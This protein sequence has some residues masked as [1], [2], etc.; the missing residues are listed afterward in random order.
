MIE[1]RSVVNYIQSRNK[2]YN[3][4]EEERCLQLI[5][6]S[7]D[8]FGANL[9]S[10]L[11]SGGSLVLLN[12]EKRKS[13]HLIPDII[14]RHKVTQM[15]LVPSMYKMI[16]ENATVED[17]ESVKKVILAA[18]KA[19]AQ[20]L[21]ESKRLNKDI[22]LINEYGPT[23]NTIGTTYHI[24]MRSEE[25]ANIGRPFANIKIY[26]LDQHQKLVPTGVPGEIYIGGDG[27]ARGYYNA[28]ELTAEKF[29]VLEDF[30][31]RL[32]RTGDLASW[33]ENGELLYRGRID[34]QIK[35]R[36]Y[37]VELGEIESCIQTYKD[38]QDTIVSAY[39]DKEGQTYLCAYYTAK[40]TIEI[41]EIK[42][43]LANTLPD[44]MVP[45]CF[46]QLEAFPKLPN[47]KVDKKALPLPKMNHY[48]HSEYEAPSDEIEE[49]L[50]TIWQELLEAQKISVL[51]SFFNLGGQS[52]KATVLISKIYKVFG[53]EIPLKEI[54]KHTTVKAQAQYIRASY[55]TE[56]A[57]IVKVKQQPYYPLSSTQKRLYV[58]HQLANE[59]TLYNTPVMLEI[60]GQMDAQKIEDIFNKLIQRHEIFRTQFIRI[61]DEIVQE[62]LK[63]V[64]FKVEKI[65]F[66]ERIEES[67]DQFVRPFILDKAP[68][69]RVGLVT[70]NEMHHMLLIDMHHII[71]DGVSGQ[72]L[73]KEFL[74]LY[75][76]NALNP[77]EVQ[78]KDY[79][80][81]QN[82]LMQSE[83]FKEEENYWLEV[84]K[85]ELPVLNLQTD[86]ARPQIQSFEGNSIEFKLSPELT[87]S[88]KALARDTECTLYMLLLAAYNV[89]LYKYTNQEDFIIGTPI[90]GRT[91]VDSQEMLGVFVN[92][93]AMRFYP[94]G[95]KS[96]KTFLEEVK[97]M[98]LEAYA[99]QDYQLEDLIDKLQVQRDL[100]RN[101]LFDT[102]F[103]VQNI[104]A[105]NQFIVENQEFNIVDMLATT[106]KFDLNLTV[107]E[108]ETLVVT[109]EYCTK[110]FKKESIK[111]LYRH[112][113]NILNSIVIDKEVSLDNITMLST[114]EENQI[115]YE[116]NDTKTSY[117]S[118]KGLI[119][120]FEEQVLRTPQSIALVYNNE[121]LTYET[122]AQKVDQLA[123][124]LSQYDIQKDELIGLMVPRSIEMIIGMLAILKVGGAYLPIDY[125]YPAERINYMLKDS[126]ARI[127]LSNDAL[128]SDIQFEGITLPL[129]LEKIQEMPQSLRTNLSV[130][131]GNDLA[132]IMYT[133]GSTGKPKGVMV[134]QKNVMR[135]VKNTNY[136]KF[137]PGSSIL[138]TGAI[139]FDASTFEVWGALLNGLTLYLV[140]EAVLLNAKRLEQAIRMYKINILWLTSPLFN[141]LVQQ[142]AR[143]FETL[144]YLLVGGDVLSYKHIS[145]VREACPGVQIINGYGPTENTTFSTCYPINHLDAQSIPIGKPISNSMAYVVNHLGALQAIGIPGELWVGGDGVARGYLNQADLTK[146]KFVENPFGLGKLYKTGDLVKWDT[147]GNLIFL[148]RID[149]QVK[150]RGFRIEIGEIERALLAIAYIQEAVIKVIGNSSSEKYLCAYIVSNE[151]IDI[152]KL[153]TCLLEK[154]PEYMLPTQY[155][156]L[157]ALPLNQNGKVDQSL[158]P[159][160]SDEVVIQKNH[161]SPSNEIEEKLV[162]I[163]QEL[164]GI[165]P[166]GVE[167]NFFELGGHSLKATTLMAQVQRAFNVEI[168]LQQIFKTPTIRQLAKVIAVSY[169][170]G[171]TPIEAAE[172]QEYYP[173]SSAQKRMYILRS[174]EDE[175][176][177]NYNIPGILL[178]EGNL[179]V[180]RVEEIF[181]ELVNR[182]EILRTSFEVIDGQVYQ[183]VNESVTVKVEY[184][185]ANDLS[186]EEVVKSSIYPF[187]LE[188][189][190]L[191]RVKLIKLDVQKHLLVYD[192]HHIISD[193]VSLGIIA[194]EF[195]KLYNNETLETIKLHYKDYAVWQNKMINSEMMKEQETYWLN[196]FAGELP[197]L[198]LKTDYNRPSIQSTEGKTFRVEVDE[199][200]TIKLKQLAQETGATLYMLLLAAYNVLIYK[201]TG[202]E[203]IIIG[204]P[205]AGRSQADLEQM[206]GMFVNTLAMRSFP[207]G[208][209]TFIE[210]LME[211]KENALM[212]YAHQ[213]Y[214][215][216]ELIDKLNLKR[217]MSRNPLF[218]CMFSLQNM[219]EDIPSQMGDVAITPISF[220]LN[221]AKFDLSIDANEIGTKI[222]F[223]FQYCTK[224]F[225]EE[226]IYR[227]ANHYNNILKSIA[228]NSHTMIAEIQMLS[229]VEQKQVLV[230][231]NLT[232][233]QNRRT[234]LA[235]ELVKK[236]A[237]VTPDKVA[238]I[239]ESQTLTYKELD[240]KAEIIASWLTYSGIKAEDVVGILVERSTNM[241]ASLLAV[242]KVGATY[243]PIDPDY[244][245]QR[246][247]YMIS[248]SNCKLVLT[249]K[250]LKN[251]M[252]QEIK[253]L[254]VDELKTG[255]RTHYNAHIEVLPEQAAYI[256]YTSGSTGKPKGVVVE[257]RNLLFYINAFL[258]E[259][260]INAED[261]M[262]QQASFC[263]DA[264]VEEVYPALVSGAS[265]VIPT[266]EAIKDITQLMKFIAHYK[267]SMISC[268]PL[269]LNEFNKQGGCKSIHTYISGGDVLKYHYIDN[270]LKHAVVYN[271]YGPTESTV[272]VTYHRC[273]LQD[274]VNIPIGKPIADTEVYILDRNKQLCAIGVPGQICV[275]GKGVTR[276]YIHA[277][278]LTQEKYQSNHLITNRKGYERI[279]YTG[280]LGRWLPDGNI[281]F[282]GRMDE[283]VK[284]RGYRI[285]LGEIE[286]RLMEI[287]GIEQSVVIPVNEDTLCAY[288]VMN[289]MLKVSDIKKQLAENLPDYMIPSAYVKLDEIPSNSNGKVDKK[290]LPNL[291][292]D[293]YIGQEYIAPE[294]E[295]EEKLVAIW[296]EVLE[297]QQI[298]IQDNFFEIGGHSLKATILAS[299]LSKTFNIKVALSTIFTCQTI[300]QLA[301]YIQG[302][303]K[304]AFEAI[305]P[306]EKQA[307]YPVSSAQK[308]LYIIEHLTAANMAYHIPYAV[309]IKGNLNQ[310][311]FEWA[312]KQLIERH[313]PLR[314]SFET[315]EGVPVQIIHDQVSIPITKIKARKEDLAQITKEF[316]KPFDL[317]IA[318]LVRVSMIEI[319]TD[320]HILLLDMHHIIIDGLSIDILV[321]EWL[322]LYQGIVLSPLAIQ[323]KDFTVWQNS[324]FGLAQMMAQER[325]WLQN[326]KGELP[327][328]NLEADFERPQEKTMA[329]DNLEFTCDK[330]LVEALK[331]LSKQ[332][333]CTTYMLLLAAYNI[334]LA[335]YS[336]Q[337]DIIVGTPI[338]GRRHADLGQMLGMFVNTLAIRN[339]LAPHKT[340]KTF[341]EEIRQNTINAFENQDYQFEELVNKLDIKRTLDRNPIFDV[342]FS[343]EKVTH[344]LDEDSE[345]QLTKLDY[346]QNVL[347][348]FDLTLHIYEDDKE[349]EFALTYST[350]LFKK[351]TIQKMSRHF[352]NILS[353]L[354]S[355]INRR[356]K[357][358]EIVTSEEKQMLLNHAMC[359]QMKYPIERTIADLFDEEVQKHPH[360]M[361]ISYNNQSLT[362]KALQLKANA[363]AQLLKDEGIKVN[364]TV[365]LL[366]PRSLEMIIGILGILKIGGTYVPIDPEYP[367]ERIRYI[368]EDSKAELLLKV[369][370]VEKATLLEEYKVMDIDLAQLKDVED[371]FK[372][373]QEALAYMIYTSGTSGM[374]KGV[375]IAQSNVVNLV[376]GLNERIYKQYDQT[377]NISLISPYVFDASIKQIFAALLLGHSLCI[378]SNEARFDGK[379]LLRFYVENNID[380]SD[381]TPL[382]LQL[383]MLAA[384][385]INEPI[386]VKRFLIGGEA[387]PVGTL[388]KWY[389]M[390]VLKASKIT[391][392]Y[393]PTECCDVSTT[394]TVEPNILEK[395]HQLP[396]GKALPNV[397]I[398]ILR[399]D[400]LVPT[401]CQGEICI[402]GLGVGKGYNHLPEM[403]KESFVPHP[404]KEGE[405]LYRTGDLGK[406]GVDGNISYLGR[407]DHQVKI[408]GYRIE[409]SEIEKCLTNMGEIKEAV[410]AA[411]EQTDKEK[412]LC[413]YIVS[414][415]AL[416]I[417]EIKAYIM[418]YLPDYMIP[419]FYIQIPN[420]PLTLNGKTDY[421][422]LPKPSEANKISRTYVAPENDIEEKLVIIWKEL[423]ETSQISTQDNFFELGGHSLKAT[424]LINKIQEV[425][426]VK[427]SLRVVFK[428]PTIQQ[429]ALE[430]MHAQKEEYTAAGQVQKQ[431]YYPLSTMQK[432]LYVLEQFEGVNTNYHIPMIFT[433]K[434]E[435]NLKHLEE[436]FKQLIARHEALRTH[437]EL[438]EGEV[439]QVI[440]DE[441]QFD[442]VYWEKLEGTIEACMNDFIKPFEL[443]KAPLL[444]VGVIRLVENE[445]LLMVDIHHLVTDGFSNKK[446]IEEFGALYEGENL[447]P[448]GLQ[449]KDYAVWE[450]QQVGQSAFKAAEDYW[451]E[452]FKGT[453]PVLDMPLDYAR[454]QV[455][456]FEGDLYNFSVDA[457]LTKQLMDLAQKNNSTLYM[458]LLASYY[459]LLAKYTLQEDCIV[460][461][462]V[463]GR[464][465]AE[466]S[467]TVGM[468]VNTLALRNYPTGNKLFKTFLNEVKESTLGALEHQNYPIELLIEKLNLSR[469]L[470]RNPL[471]DTVFTLQNIDSQKE[472]QLSGIQL[473]SY[474]HKRK[475]SK[476]DFSLIATMQ[477]E[478]I[479]FVF[480][481]CTAL[482]SETTIK[483]FAKSYIQILKKVIENEDLEISKIDVLQVEEKHKLLEE[484]NPIIQSKN[485]YAT[486]TSMFK[487]VA[488]KYANHVAVKYDKDKITYEALDKQSNTLAAYLKELGICKNCIVG[489]IVENSIE[490]IVGLLAILKAGGAYLPIDPSYPLERKQYMLRDSHV[491]VLLTQKQFKDELSFEGEVV[492]IELPLKV[493]QS[494][495]RVEDSN[496]GEDLAYVIYTSGTTG[497]P[498]GVMVTH[499]G[500]SNYI[501]WR[502]RN[503]E[504][505]TEDTT[506][507]LLSYAF[508][509]FGSNCYGSLLSGGTLILMPQDKVK[510]YSYVVESIKYYKVTHMSLVPS[511]YEAILA[512]STKEDIQTLRCI[513]LAAEKASVKLIQ[514]S[515]CINPNIKLVNEYG[516]TENSITTTAYVNFDEQHVESIGKPIDNHQ[517]YI[518]DAYKQLVPF[519][520]AGEIYVSGIGLA[521]GYIGQEALT[522]Q[523]FINNPF[524]P[525][526][527]MYRTGDRAKWL[528]DGTLQFLGRLDEQVKIRGYRIELS[529]IERQIANIAGVKQVVVTVIETNIGEKEIVAYIVGEQV[530]QKQEIIKQLTHYLPQYMIPSYFINLEYIPLNSNGK[531]D[532]K[533]LVKPCANDKLKVEYI[534]PENAIEEKLAVIWEEILGIEQVGVEDEF[535]EIGGHSLKATLL[536]A[537]IHQMFNYKITLAEIFTHTTIRKQ[538][539]L[540]IRSDRKVQETEIIPLAEK[541]EFYPMSPMQKRMY[542]LSQMDRESTYYNMP[543]A[544]KIKQLDIAQL[545]T[546]FT[547]LI[548]RHEI[549]RTKFYTKDNAFVQEVCEDV[550]FKMQ[551][552]DLSELTSSTLTREK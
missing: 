112:F 262:L 435:V 178:I 492:D 335:R 179:D 281:E 185:A 109:I 542:I 454:P 520:V 48:E 70:M 450:N 280:D 300:K 221:Q 498:K 58:V 99:H 321:Q 129:K 3:I 519:N 458:V 153:R 358:I 196:Q 482:Y 249:Q 408:R 169:K 436:S 236:Q 288:I 428:A 258:N 459:I 186:I 250:Q 449:Y 298:G 404:F 361:A 326:L 113:V 92:T 539:E 9:Y 18:E 400:Q 345:L 79:V 206:V 41:K 396:I 247:A 362:Y 223:L 2:Q 403:T 140:D 172:K 227:M 447:K 534:P 208:K 524:I 421:K 204:S 144:D 285:E 308:R 368:L 523:K 511:M 165:M 384:Q 552:E 495:I 108:E 312:F 163:W 143:M 419:T 540:I 316:M 414:E 372:G 513:V 322:Q 352:I 533:A 110:L 121:S 309:Q 253:S 279:Y 271:T 443:N 39:R 440:E 330:K 78:Y 412:V 26:I 367:K 429:L 391:N 35:I 350:Q 215:F 43:F 65:E 264:F 307:Y 402:G 159:Q 305:T 463:A 170:K 25:I 278:E 370:N 73:I 75:K 526:Q 293:H 182:H 95:S 399:N 130:N 487:E 158:L 240:E 207:E 377:L 131:A 331:D 423:L 80:F 327:I 360:T 180:Q 499:Q 486:L 528:P 197:V 167:D 85:G 120:V 379:E 243:L 49:K 261:R 425:F 357:D 537:K 191:I 343:Y 444:R 115:V 20:L 270:L 481:Y 501:A 87:R 198:N 445:Y 181:K 504:L 81:W 437:F 342:F 189:A 502:I 46:M 56:Y 29:I 536:M 401:L 31:E 383:I 405:K 45:T 142:N 64:V 296:Q 225:K 21:K 195:T 320:V 93:L 439:V 385:S 38:I 464:N 532:Y 314:T 33:S 315:K 544:Y 54:F 122:L 1:H 349:M 476:L 267:V 291:L 229:Q 200:T 292:A 168:T 69:I 514:T 32:Y 132:Y 256:I 151:T 51:D 369:S 341:L 461:L 547:K 125:K 111:R 517:V 90:A 503:Y 427:L 543:S 213:D 452:I 139:V 238:V 103:T 133:S 141:Q 57:P 304:Q 260:M 389:Q 266:K 347:S 410:V 506:L 468:F 346:L 146:E 276:G 4:S 232:Q 199:E 364:Q 378:A 217:D 477:E 34:E 162:E 104:S 397:E 375:M 219:A 254:Y 471:F 47:G 155:I 356:I 432:R 318:P 102:L 149:N 123:R 246:I 226:T 148:G 183:K 274:A 101:P 83:K 77:L 388:Q 210:F 527:L 116:F 224:L 36:G 205:I 286:K 418:Q 505:G 37:R 174:L 74:T 416:D 348:K 283:Q 13:Y 394:Y 166:I 424:L 60:K 237:I 192:M 451:H 387:L 490:M 497:L 235:H 135:L 521:K 248:D 193:G 508:D 467:E 295:I 381:G 392:V 53:I 14:K 338:A 66:K 150:I 386:K 462:P 82:Q 371:S 531:V 478:E 548:M 94:S 290:A 134:T 353:A 97:K 529:E 284:I 100:G 19:D 380:I 473:K 184:T 190:P 549:L 398:Y 187:K 489:M 287:K 277:L 289:D 218:D 433:L 407:I 319:E 328:L 203:D 136:I 105:D 366:M 340:I 470:S 214:Q 512:W 448:V 15:S 5:S 202:Q 216:E 98:T 525:G 415:T 420:I 393:G 376:Y 373:A 431:A 24:G 265:I 297:I 455:Q 334:L 241:I 395:M 336:D 430:I 138:Q 8:G 152:S 530:L 282:L 7:F 299:K 500:V 294:N 263:F 516:P 40:E 491:K 442:L 332:T 409:L 42:A 27:L 201:Y 175:D 479:Q 417:Q 306:I 333:G 457:N 272:C 11:L 106:S 72:L 239:S 257:H 541:A 310:E 50:V 465:R 460:G 269:L 551:T 510:D 234:L 324:Q 188:E 323:Y 173:V 488:T 354:V 145:A 127:L 89:L 337:E 538:A 545:E 220:D 518:L 303:R 63:E 10:S 52:L 438:V 509:G 434:G 344:Q 176:N 550:A 62:I 228:E 480:E 209:K 472:I 22:V 59:K 16:L 252:N 302:A 17:L 466:Y 485:K 475:E 493:Q 242:L 546:A 71:T 6:P 212:A 117:E 222:E 382:H 411:I 474:E 325:F 91:H 157:P 114:Q 124:I 365:V 507:Q 126:H 86:Y 496:I 355:D 483:R 275:A 422:A 84:F 230:D 453:L 255:C 374:P 171:Y 231:F 118:E 28:E 494:N 76:G 469:D 515:K 96:F 119:E 273:H 233:I 426:D 317:A 535:F 107:T 311:Q 44:Y 61:N 128:E 160:P 211:V 413:A 456:S 259:F 68:L 88:L 161:I 363:V 154:L 67:I 55:K 251:K 245:L 23:E 359:E 313:E 12:E 137:E 164:L 30:E 329:G 351:E 194:R 406:W 339:N 446:L 484:F 244:P 147:E 301:E 177:I 268:S 390:K 522:H 156:Q 441:V